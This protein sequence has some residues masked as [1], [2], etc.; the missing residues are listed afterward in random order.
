M[1][2]DFAIP[3]DPALGPPR[4]AALRG[5]MKKAGV[6]GFLVPRADAHQGEFVAARDARLGW[7]TGFTGSAGLAVVLADAA[8]LFVDG[9]Y[10][11]Q[12]AAQVDTGVL[13]LKSVP[14]DKPADWARGHLRQGQT[15]AYD[16][17]LHTARDI[18]DWAEV[19]D[20]ARIA[21]RPVD[22]LVDAIWDDQP[23]P[24]AGRAEVQPLEFS[25]RGHGDKRSEVAGTLRTEGVKAAVLTLPDSI[26]WLLNI[27]GSDVARIPVM[28]GFAILHADGRVS[29]FADPAKLDETVRRHLGA[30]VEI[31][32]PEEFGAALDALP[33]PVGVDRAS[34]PAWVS[35]RLAAAGTEVRW[36][37][38]PC[39]LPK[40]CK[41][42]AELAGSRAAHLRDGAAMVEFLCWLDGA[43][44]GG[45]LTEID[46]V[47]E[48]E[49]RRRATNALR[50]LSFDTICG[51]GPHGAIVHYRVTD[52]TNRPI[53]PG[54]VLLVDSGG[55]Y[56]D[57]TT[58]ITRT[59]ATGAVDPDARRAF[60]LVLKG[61]IAMSRA[62]WPEGL[63]GRD[64]DA[65]ARIAL[66]RAGM[67]YDHGTGHGVG[68][69]LG[70][71]EG[72]AGLSRRSTE[73]LK[74]GMILS[75]EPGYYRE[76][77]FGIRIEN[78]LAVTE[79]RVPDGGE[80]PMLG[81]ETL[82]YVPID[83]RLIDGQLLSGEER[84]WL[85]SYHRTVRDR[86]APLVSDKTRDWL[87]DATRA[88]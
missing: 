18:A 74:P 23:P 71:H 5:A 34:A 78:L 46:V 2:Q 35:D 22:N 87:S 42:G 26:A 43:V 58:D 79:P 45:T 76:G 64:L 41:T 68:A 61:M 84:D 72:P 65:L 88:L 47:Q 37:R 36:M 63:A 14:A 31:A 53:A 40:A 15:V 21:L 60:T 49:A 85:D 86:L 77:A 6:D 62:R 17:W 75:N 51:A 7:L 33:G 32:A 38:D 82:T 39:V 50:D 30:E 4:I 70:V 25:G 54:D 48:L 8:A 13:T 20:P 16:P 66:W 81:F 83:L 59:V 27:R 67:D 56:A 52:G 3:S 80:R 29:L 19:L 69:Y 55:Q 24:P 10:T 11:L 57:G 28:H 44:A 1:F 73:P 9:R 12:A